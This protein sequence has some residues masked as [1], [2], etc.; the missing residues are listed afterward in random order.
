LC[1][2][3][4]GFW[5]KN[6]L[7]PEEFFHHLDQGIIHE[8]ASAD[9]QTIHPNPQESSQKDRD[10]KDLPSHASSLFSMRVANSAIREV[11]AGTSGHTQLA[12]S[13][14]WTLHLPWAS[15]DPFIAPPKR[16][17]SRFHYTASRGIGNHLNQNPLPFSIDYFYQDSA[18]TVR[19]TTPPCSR[20]RM[21]CRHAVTLPHTR[22]CDWA[23]SGTIA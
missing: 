16:H 6:C 2:L 22:R 1:L 20:P 9:R 4:L 19:G 3:S 18:R 12:L 5:H 10:K 21:S 7:S 14:L 13:N 17:N 15:C 11:G 8:K 23:I